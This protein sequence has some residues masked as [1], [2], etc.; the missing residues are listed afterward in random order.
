MQPIADD[1]WG[2]EESLSI[3]PGMRMPA[4]ATV[5][6]LANGDVVLH[7]PLRLDD[8]TAAAISKLGPVKA[9]L[10]PNTVHWMFARAAAE[11]FP[12]ATLFGAPGLEKKLGA[13]TPLPADGFVADGLRSFLVGGAPRMNEHVFLYRKTLVVSDLVM[14]IHR[15][16]SPLMS[17]FLRINGVHGRFAHSRM[18]KVMGADAAAMARSLATIADWEFERIVP[19]HGDVKEDNAR[20][21]LGRVLK[22]PSPLPGATAPTARTQTAPAG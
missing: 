10:A 12:S 6:R 7:S 4:R 3:G 15:D 8:A 20:A 1:V 16:F 21:E 18:W 22:I 2:I 14:N 11:R 9:I 5:V 13:F 19:A 17:V